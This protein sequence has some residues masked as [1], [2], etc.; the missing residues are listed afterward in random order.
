M[1]DKTKIA[2]IIGPTASGKTALSIALAKKY[3]GEIICCDSM[4]IYREMNIGT[5]KPT[6]HETEGVPHHLFDFVDPCISYS[7]ADYVADAR[8]KID[9]IVSNGKLPII[10]GGTGLYLDSLLRQGYFEDIE[11]LPEYREELQ[12]LAIDEGNEKVHA[13]LRE[14]DPESADAIHPNNLKRVIRAL[15]IYKSSGVP[16]SELDKRSVE[17]DSPYDALVIGLRFIDRQALYARINRRVDIMIEQGLE[18]E[19]RRLIANGVFDSNGTAAQA[20]GYKELL[21]YINGEMTL[22]EAIDAL[23]TASR[24]YAKRQMTWFG[25]KEYV[26]WID[27]DEYNF[28]NILNNAANLFNNFV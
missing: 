6:P 24:R 16:K 2:A 19:T 26:H 1:A 21:G 22:P 28:E 10:C 27:V 25:A 8:A 4:Q 5:A 20:I 3:N 12:R 9:E 18:D 23:K 17:G 11:T 13:L 14:V 15:E 7:C